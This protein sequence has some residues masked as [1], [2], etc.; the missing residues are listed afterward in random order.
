[1][2]VWHRGKIPTPYNTVVLKPQLG[3]ARARKWAEEAYEE[4]I[5][6]VILIAQ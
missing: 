1:L 4:G 2:G 3:E 5:Y 6:S